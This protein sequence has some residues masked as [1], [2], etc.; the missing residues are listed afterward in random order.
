V[1]KTL[2]LKNVYWTAN[3]TAHLQVKAVLHQSQNFAKKTK[4]SFNYCE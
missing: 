2:K 3:C 4:L 1:T